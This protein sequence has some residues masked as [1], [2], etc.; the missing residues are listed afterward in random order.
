[1][2]K[3]FLK[4]KEKESFFSKVINFVLTLVLAGAIG[5]QVCGAAN[6]NLRIAQVS[7]VHLSTFEENT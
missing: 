1:M 5:V 6:N 3:K 7:D 2:D 4:K